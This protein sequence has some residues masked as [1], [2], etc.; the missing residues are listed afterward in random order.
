MHPSPFLPVSASLRLSSLSTVYICAHIHADTSTRE[1]TRELESRVAGR[2][3]VA[4]TLRD[5]TGI[6]GLCV[7]S[8]P[9]VAWLPLSAVIPELGPWAVVQAPE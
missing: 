1:H 4:L 6:V 8:V 3:S 7:S 9:A 2:P 5:C